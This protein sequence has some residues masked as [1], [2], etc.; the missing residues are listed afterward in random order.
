MDPSDKRVILV[1]WA[2]EALQASVTI[3]SSTFTVTVVKQGGVTA[4][5]FDNASIPSGNRTT[6]VRLDATTATSGDKYL[7]NNAI[8]TAETPA[9]TLER[10]FTV[11]VQNQ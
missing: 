5:T 3:A 9:Q 8:V 4:L 11:L 10:Q 1:D 2:S 6:K 7:V